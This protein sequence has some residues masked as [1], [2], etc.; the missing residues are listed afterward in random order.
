LRNAPRG[1]GLQFDFPVGDGQFL[2]DVGF[3]G[4]SFSL[5]SCHC[6][7]LRREY[8]WLPLEL[9]N[10]YIARFKTAR[11]GGGRLLK[12]THMLR[13]RSIAARQRS[14]DVPLRLACPEQSRR[15]DF[16][17]AS[18]IF[19]SSLKSR[20]FSIMSALLSMSAFPLKT[21]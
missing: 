1:A 18:K 15:I 5:A 19:L 12:E 14:A 10:F 11:L 20:L 9:H 13:L 2:R 7:Q 17:F 6:P 8:S 3:H 16:S 4:S 21:H